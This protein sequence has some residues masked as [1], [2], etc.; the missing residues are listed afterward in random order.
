LLN[1]A[2]TAFHRIKNFEQ[3]IEDHVEQFIPLSDREKDEV[4]SIIN[5]ANK[6]RN[7]N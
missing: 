5:A 1:K 2:V 7:I 3:A 6:T 4:E